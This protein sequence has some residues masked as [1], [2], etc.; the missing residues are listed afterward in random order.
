MTIL[1]VGCSWTWGYG[2]QP[3]E[4]YSAHLQDFLGVNVI[5]AGTC[6]TDI[7][8]SIYSTY[9]LLDHIQPS[10]V[11]FQL[12]TF[13]RITLGVSGKKNF[14]DQNYIVNKP[15]LYFCNGEYERLNGIGDSEKHLVTIGSYTE[16]LDNTDSKSISTKFLMENVIFD[17]YTLSNTLI[18]ITLLQSHLKMQ[19]INYAFFPWFDLPNELDNKLNIHHKSAIDFLGDEFFIDKG[20]HIS[21]AGN[22][23][24]AIEFIYPMIEEVL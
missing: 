8:Q 12:T 4:T 13:D 10:I 18:D 5:N 20:Y 3:S 23:K 17:E 22:K 21:N 6:G 7:K 15:N 11:I 9:Q 24:L 1:T 2:L 14:V 19:G 16:C